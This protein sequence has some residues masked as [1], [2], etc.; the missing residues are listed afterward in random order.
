MQ[1]ISQ[2]YSSVRARPKKLIS[3]DCYT[4]FNLIS[5]DLKLI[6]TLQLDF[7]CCIFSEKKNNSMYF[8]RAACNADAVL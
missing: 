8:Y 3:S 6:S 1:M 7:Y 4:I 2:S 5:S